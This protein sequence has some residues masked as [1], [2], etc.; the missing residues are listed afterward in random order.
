MTDYMKNQGLV[1]GITGCRSRQRE[2]EAENAK[3]QA[4][5]AAA[6]AVLPHAKG[7]VY[8]GVKVE[9]LEEALS[10]LD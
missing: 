10:A 7:Q 6:K 4:V 3:L 2:L 8:D 5:A 1:D 9:C